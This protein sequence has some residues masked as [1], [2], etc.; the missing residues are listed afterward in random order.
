MDAE[1]V[2]SMLNWKPLTNRNLL[3]G[4]IGSIGYLADD[5]LN[6]R[7]PIGILSKI[8]GDAIPFHWG[9]T[10]QRTFE[11]VKS[12]TQ[13]AWDHSQALIPYKKRAPPV[14]LIT[15]GSSTGISGVVSQ[16]SDWK[17][18]K[19][20]VFYSAKLN[21]TQRNYPVHEIEMLAGIE[22]MLWHRD[23]LQGVQFKWLTDHKGLTYLLNQKNVLGRQAR[24]LEKMS[25]FMFEV[26]YMPGSENIVAD[27]LSQMY[28]EDDAGTERTVSEFTYHDV[29]DD[30]AVALLE[31]P[32]LAGVQAVVATRRSVRTRKPTNKVMLNEENLTET[33]EMLA[34]FAK[35]MQNKF[36]LRGPR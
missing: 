14:W 25:S 30:D 2:D 19:I 35:C 24:W 15:D 4:F 33:A 9:Y 3:R 36:V 34:S 21:D 7:I 16:G 23:I 26:V 32:M 17:L 20:A 22:T 5:I 12:L 6:V 18:V 11:D 28:S 8:T 13:R 10:E 1:K 31:M 27:A 29:D